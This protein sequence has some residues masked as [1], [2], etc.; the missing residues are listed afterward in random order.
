MSE[1]TAVRAGRAEEEEL[2]GPGAGDDGQPLSI[3]LLSAGWPPDAYPNGVV[4]YVA[5]LAEGLEA[6]GH[7]V[8]ILTAKVAPGDWGDRVC[9]LGRAG[10]RRGLPRRAA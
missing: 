2:D 9:L 4:T 1:Y 7:R 5:G 3:G 10:D 6:L 8:T